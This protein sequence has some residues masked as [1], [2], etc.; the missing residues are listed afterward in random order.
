MQCNSDNRTAEH[1]GHFMPFLKYCSVIQCVRK[2]IF[3]WFLHHRLCWVRD[4]ICKFSAVC[5]C[6]KTW[7]N[8][9]GHRVSCCVLRSLNFCDFAGKCEKGF[10]FMRPK[11]LWIWQ[12]AA[13]FNNIR[14]I[15]T[16]MNDSHSTKQSHATKWYLAFLNAYQITNSTVYLSLFSAVY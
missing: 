9:T 2:T 1:D 7:L 4:C 15:I 8:G 5:Q 16:W 10:A 14:V 13:I 12:G 6:F 11:C 3:Y